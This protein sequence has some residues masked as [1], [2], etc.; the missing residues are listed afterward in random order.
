VSKSCVVFSPS[1]SIIAGGGQDHIVRTFKYPSFG[2]L[3][4]FKHHQN[5]IQ[6]ISFNCDSSLMAIACKETFCSIW[7]VDH[8]KMWTLSFQDLEIR[9]CAFSVREPH[10]MYAWLNEKGHGSRLLLWDVIS[11]KILKSVWRSCSL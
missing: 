1:G 7:H 4:Q 10:F 2:R 8:S 3:N 6:T 11:G 5:L 9:G